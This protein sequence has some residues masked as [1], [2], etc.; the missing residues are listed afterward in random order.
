MEGV[1]NPKHRELDFKAGGHVWLNSAHLPVRQ[2]AHKFSPK[3]AGPF[4]VERQVS[5]EAYRLALP[6]SW[7][8]H[9]VFHTS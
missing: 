2:G 5:R 9:P 8:I 7:R 1:A 3:W 6:S 4:A